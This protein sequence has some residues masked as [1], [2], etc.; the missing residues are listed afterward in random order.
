MMSGIQRTCQVFPL[1]TRHQ[2]D[3]RLIEARLAL[4]KAPCKDE[5]V[6]HRRLHPSSSHDDFPQHSASG[7]RVRRSLVWA[8]LARAM[9]TR[10]QAVD[11]SF[12]VSRLKDYLI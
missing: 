9:A 11:L 2:P 4:W 6:D 1:F 5:A 3:D 10:L 12:R 8:R 7:Q